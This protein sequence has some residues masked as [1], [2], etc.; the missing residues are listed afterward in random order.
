M[1]VYVGAS[2][3]GLL[4]PVYVWSRDPTPSI[5]TL[6]LLCHWR[7]RRILVK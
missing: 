1:Y 7:V 3:T 4:L 6:Y 5:E 2:P